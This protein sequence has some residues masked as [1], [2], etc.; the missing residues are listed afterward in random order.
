MPFAPLRVVEAADS[1]AK[2]S[3]PEPFS[4]SR[5]SNWVA[6][7]GGL[8]DYV[9]H[10][11]HDLLE[12]GRAKDESS[13]IR[14]A[15]GIVQN[16][17]KN[18]GADA[19]AAAAKA[20]AEWEK[21]KGANKLGKMAASL[22]PSAEDLRTLRDTSLTRL[23]VCEQQIGLDGMI[24]MLL[25]GAVLQE[26]AAW[27]PTLKRIA[28]G[29]GE[30]ER[31]EV[32]DGGQLVGTISRRP[33]YSPSEGD[34][35]HAA[36]INGD[37]VGDHSMRSQAQAVDSL[38]KHLEEAPA[39]VTP[40]RDGKYLIARPGYGAGPMTYQEYPSQ[41]TARFAAGLPAE[42]STPET[43]SQVQALGEALERDLVMVSSEDIPPLRR[44][45]EARRSVPFVREEFN[46]GE[47][48]GRGGR[49]IGGGRR[50]LEPQGLMPRGTRTS[51]GGAP[52][53]DAAVRYDGGALRPDAR[54][55]LALQRMPQVALAD[56]SKSVGRG[57]WSREVPKVTRDLIGGRVADTEHAYRAHN[58]D[59]SLGKYTPE[60][61][62]LHERIVTQLLAGKKPHEGKARAIFTAGGPASGKSKMIEDGHIKVPADPVHLNPDVVRE[63]L[64]EYSKM[65]A[66]G[67]QD[68]SQLTHE[69]ASHVTKLATKIALGR[70]HHVLIDSVGNSEPGKFLGKVKDA[71]AAGYAA[72]VHYATV[73]TEEALV[74]AQKRAKRTGRQVPVDYLKAAHAG[75][76]ARFPDVAKLPG[77]HVQVFDN[78]GPSLKLIAE[79]PATADKIHIADGPRFAAFLR[80]GR[81]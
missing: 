9:Q 73:P 42:P 16:P 68:A 59:G 53:S 25:G 72:S 47:L 55:R 52:K 23:A 58:P 19:R 60:R 15:I 35:Y 50:E 48:R 13:A 69:E 7:R 40:H 21:M 63:M 77:V 49:W 70:Q 67:R 80:K 26:A 57:A 62:A 74:R 76:S 51:R 3:T 44:V 32:H 33:A 71:Q 78:T 17:P 27:T 38:K 46:Q 22:V 28:S 39:R 14:L 64:P 45:Q 81:G 66:A 54:A 41:A 6:R 30:K 20:S 34:R 37:R 12:S 43:N 8:P 2:A 11:A 4:T 5:T 18:W 75:A 65:L 1:M 31:H 79:K 24:S 36:A 56:L 10:I 61:K 29:S